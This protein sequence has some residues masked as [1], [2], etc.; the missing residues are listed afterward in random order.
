MRL[1]LIEDNI[2][3]AENIV[4]YLQHE[5]MQ[6]DTATT[7][8]Q[9]LT[10]LQTGVY[11][12]LL[13]DLMLPDIDGMTICE[14]VKKTY[15]I[16]IIITSAKSDIDDKAEWFG[17]GA[18]D[19]LTKPFDLQEL[20]LRIRAVAQRSQT[21]DIVH[22]KNIRINLT[23]R[24]ISKW[25]KE[26][27]LSIKEFHILAYLITHRWHAVSRTDIIEDVWWGDSVFAHESDS[28]LDVYI[29]NLR[30][31]LDKDLIETIKWFGYTLSHELHT[32]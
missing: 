31:K 25:G 16:P 12:M 6:C 4:A 18:D 29:A 10:M 3:I 19:Y 1:L 21:N 23:R 9:W 30:K 2:P 5:G 7:G 26:I 15:H 8:K 17:K 24:Q 27:S 32:Y 20:V 11:A 28:K 13:L 14:T 22:Y